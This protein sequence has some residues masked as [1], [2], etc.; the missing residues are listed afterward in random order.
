MLTGKRKNAS[1]MTSNLLLVL[2]NV[3]VIINI[4][5]LQ[6]KVPCFL[7]FPQAGCVWSKARI[8]GVKKT[9][10]QS[11]LKKIIS[12]DRSEHK[13]TGQQSQHD[14]MSPHML[15]LSPSSRPS[16]FWTLYICHQISLGSITGNWPFFKVVFDAFWPL[17][18]SSLDNVW[19]NRS[20]HRHFF[21]CFIL[22]HIYLAE[23]L[24]KNKTT[25]WLCI[26]NWC[27]MLVR[28]PEP[29][30]KVERVSTACATEHFPLTICHR[31]TTWD[32]NEN[33]IQSG[34]GCR[35]SENMWTQIC[36]M[37]RAQGVNKQ[38]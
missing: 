22:T 10:N 4:R 20:R 23:Y 29:N 8:S 27:G 7:S 31:K 6:S 30:D 16:P 11:A 5:H 2:L 12:Q 3:W 1:L 15:G 38:M 14:W 9:S 37:S 24:K 21:S 35:G 17:F 32:I 19:E 33:H 26:K 25:I 18:G 34:G 36:V 28:A 13:E